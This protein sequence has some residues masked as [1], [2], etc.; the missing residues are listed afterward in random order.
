MQVATV[1][2]INLHY[3]VFGLGDMRGGGGGGVGGHDPDVPTIVFAN[4]L[5]TDFRIWDDVVACLSGRFRLICYDKRGHGLSDVTPAPYKLDDHVADLSALLDVLNIEKFVL[6]GLSVGGQIAQALAARQPDRVQAL[7][8]MDTAHKIG[9]PAM[10][11]ERMDA[12]ADGGIAAISDK[13]M[14]RW[15]SKGFRV[16]RPADFS[17]YHNMLVRTPFDGYAGTC[18]ALRA[19]DLT[20]STRS[21]SLPVQVICG[22]EDGSTPPD[23]VKSMADLIPG[24]RFALVEKAGH[25][26]CIEHPAIVADII[27]TFL[28]EAGLADG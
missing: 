23:L 5:G 14:E 8:L 4:S 16:D 27:E 25:L 15:F 7:V 3:G 21:L 24:A 1:N 10:W 11:Q 2:N 12:L 19:T 18:A 9:T 20:E 28:R 13:I 6:C 22:D 17:M 26:P